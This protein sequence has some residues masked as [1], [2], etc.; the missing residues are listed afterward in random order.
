MKLQSLII[1]LLTLCAASGTL[2][3]DIVERDTLKRTLKF[4]GAGDRRILVDNVN[5]WI[6]VTGYDGDDVELVA[7]RRIDAE[8]RSRLEEAKREVTLDI[9]EDG[10]RIALY[11]D[12]PWRR[13]DG[14]VNY[15]GWDYYGYS[16]EYDFELRVP[17]TTDFTLKTVNSG[18]IV[19][20]KLTGDF[21]VRNVNGDVE[22]IGIAGSG[23]VSTVNGDIEVAFTKNPPE[24]SSFR[25]VNGKVD[26]EFPG[27]VSANLR[28]KT[29]NGDVYTD[30]PVKSLPREAAYRE[31]RNGMKVYKSG[32]AFTVEAGGGGPELSFDTLN[33][34]IYLSLKGDKE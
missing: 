20:R 15:R 6:D 21:E 12:A 17:A 5:G 34:D 3:G 2:A 23:N 30:F 25:T 27:K 4:A 28:F 26:V 7:Y 13:N 29:M 10:D 8:S 31:K 16:V 19:A 32:D 22:L 11:V 1:A 33:G 18:D 9:R 24:A 14:S